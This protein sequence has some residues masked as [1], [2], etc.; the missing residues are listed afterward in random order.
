MRGRLF[1]QGARPP[2]PNRAET[3]ARAE[4]R[5]FQNMEKKKKE[6]LRKLKESFGN[7]S[8]TCEQVGVSRQTF[9]QWRREDEEFNAEVE[10]IN[11]RTIDFVESKL[12][13]GINEGSARLIMF[14]LMNKART[15]GYSP[16][17]EEQKPRQLNVVITEDEAEF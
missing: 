16:K 15:R 17:P 2:F 13:Q 14:Y 12:I 8:V 3:N 4:N 6:A 1:Q 9:Y 10:E 11:E 5:S 7:I